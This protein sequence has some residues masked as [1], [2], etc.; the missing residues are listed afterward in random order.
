MSSAPLKDIYPVIDRVRQGAHIRSRAQYDQMYARSVQDPNGF[1]GDLAREKLAWMKPFD[2]VSDVDMKAGH[3][4]WF[5]GG[6]LNVSVNCL[7]RHL[8][9]RGDQ[10]AIIWEGDEPGDVR[11][12]TYRE[13]HH[14][15]CRFANALALRGVRKGDKI[16]IYMPMIP[17]A[18]VAML[19]CARLGAIHSVI[20]GGF[21]A[22]SVRDRVLDADCRVLVTADEGLR[23]RK[24]AAQEDRR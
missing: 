24:V 5:T 11:R 21:S 12:I 22:E 16:A 23:G 1:W 8:E 6:Q 20:F 13:L 7:D 9:T 19:A 14:D 18:A 3:H 2:R 15:V 17:E 10:I 4:T